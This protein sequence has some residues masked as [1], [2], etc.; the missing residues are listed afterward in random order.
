M[1]KTNYLTLFLLE[2]IFREINFS[3][4][5]S[6]FSTETAEKTEVFSQAETLVEQH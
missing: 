6:L 3:L 1:L 2:K 4:S 5:L